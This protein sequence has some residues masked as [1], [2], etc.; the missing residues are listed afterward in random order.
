M[1]LTW[2]VV[3]A[4]VA[5]GL[6]AALGRINPA[7]AEK[8][9]SW[10]GSGWPAGPMTLDEREALHYQEAER[11]VREHPFQPEGMSFAQ[12]L[13]QPEG[14]SFAQGLSGWDVQFTAEEAESEADSTLSSC[15]WAADP[16][17]GGGPEDG[18]RELK[19]NIA[20]YEAL[21]ER[22]KQRFLPASTIYYEYVL[23][24]LREAI[25]EFCGGGP[26][27]PW[28]PVTAGLPSDPAVR[29]LFGRPSGCC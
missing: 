16:E 13:S 12:G 25:P 6:L 10:L 15:E 27:G 3:S 1:V 26:G 5:S 19:A 29:K 11:W 17:S 2:A 21:V 9:S 28:A 22:A 23:N 24:R 18:C 7:L 20:K 8:I 14:M 4:L